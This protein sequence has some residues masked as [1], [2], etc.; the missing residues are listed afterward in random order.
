MGAILYVEASLPAG[1]LKVSLRSLGDT[2]TTVIS[3]KFGGGGH[4]NASS[5]NVD[6]ST[7]LSWKVAEEKQK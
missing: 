3:K 5:F 1:T 4:L 2:D 7:C 6:K